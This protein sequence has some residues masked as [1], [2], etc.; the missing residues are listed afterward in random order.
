MV[1]VTPTQRDE[2]RIDHVEVDGLDLRYAIRPGSGTP[3]LIFNGIGANMELVRPFVDALPGR[4]IILFDIPGIGGSEPMLLPRR[5]R[6][7]VRLVIKMLDRLGYSQ[8][9]AAGVSWGGALAQQFAKQAGERCRRLIL[10]A[11]SPGALMIPGKPR[12]LW[13][14]ATPKRYL[15]SMYMKLVAPE[16]YG[17]RIRHRPSLVDD[18]AAR[19][20]PPRTRGYVYQLLAGLGWTSI[21]WLHRLKQPVLLMAGDDDPL[22]PVANSRIMELL[23]PHSEL[24]VVE[25]GGHLFMIT[26]AQE[27][28]PIIEEFLDRPDVVHDAEPLA[29]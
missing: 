11:T 10:A 7:L 12:V 24:V 23:I 5:F 20:V 4:E 26:R 15:S 28:A 13:K 18:H 3:L 16:I 14:M 8:V 1:A 22:V 19:I 27:V 25:G 9:D 6:G 21:H 2:L 17:G 29:D